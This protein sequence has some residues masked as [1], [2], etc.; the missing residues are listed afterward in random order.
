MIAQV[1]GHGENARPPL[2]LPVG[3]GIVMKIPVTESPRQC[4]ASS[5]LHAHVLLRP[6][7]DLH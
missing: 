2:T 4:C 5:Y 3:R 6:G 7:E 1:N